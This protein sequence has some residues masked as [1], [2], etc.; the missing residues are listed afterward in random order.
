[1]ESGPYGPIRCQ[2]GASF[3]WGLVGEDG[4]ES[5]GLKYYSDISVIYV[6]NYMKK[7]ALFDKRFDRDHYY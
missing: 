7:H 5:R 2:H 1:M 4:V 6:V 3:R